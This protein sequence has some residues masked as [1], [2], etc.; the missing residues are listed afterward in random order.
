MCRV[1]PAYCFVVCNTNGNNSQRPHMCRYMTGVQGQSVAPLMRAANNGIKA[2][3]C[4]YRPTMFLN[5]RF[6]RG[7][8]TPFLLGMLCCQNSCVVP[9]MRKTS[10]AHKL[11]LIFLLL[12]W[13]CRR[14]KS[15]GVPNETDAM[16]GL[17]PYLH[18]TIVQQ[19]PHRA[20]ADTQ[21]WWLCAADS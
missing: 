14:T 7:C 12:F 11:T 20:Q 13:W 2:L 1:W 19:Q 21:N 15:R 17:W 10:P 9:A 3:S 16:V 8:V 4:C 18:M 5:V 6:M